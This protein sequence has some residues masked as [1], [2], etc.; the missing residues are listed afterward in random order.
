MLDTSKNEKLAKVVIFV[1]VLAWSV[2][3]PGRYVVAKIED[4]FLEGVGG[5]SSRSWREDE[6]VKYIQGQPLSGRVYSNAPDAIY[7]LVGTAAEFT[8]RRYR[9][10][11]NKTTNESL[12]TLT[13]DISQHN[14]YIVWFE[15]MKRNYLYS[16][17][18]IKDYLPLHNVFSSDDGNVYRIVE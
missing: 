14:I 11:S 10:N 9:H 13:R 7:F 18:E 15:K 3:Y 1:L 12:K 8:P 2:A 4:S 5:Y 6:V 16:I 17:N